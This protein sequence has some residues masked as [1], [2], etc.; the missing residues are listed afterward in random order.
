[1]SAEMVEEARL[2]RIESRLDH[3][4]ARLSELKV[5][6]DGRFAELKG[7]ID[8][9]F[10]EVKADIRELRGSLASLSDTHHRDFRLIFGALIAVALGLAGLMAR[11][12]HWF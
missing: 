9:R 10:A 7:S 8:A 5:G 1:M 2:V 3:I 11:G 12:F 4:E 6:V